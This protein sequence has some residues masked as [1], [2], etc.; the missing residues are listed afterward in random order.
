MLALITKFFIS[1]I[2]AYVGFCLVLFVIQRQMI[3]SPDKNFPMIEETGYAGF[4]R[5]STEDSLELIGW[6]SPP[7]IGKKTLVYF[8]GNAGHIGHRYPL[9]RSY[10]DQGYGV[11]LVEYRGYGG[12]PGSPSE[13]GFYRDARAYIEFLKARGIAESDLVLYGESIGSGVA[14]Q[15]A[16]EYPKAS[17]LLLVTPFSS[18]LAL[19]KKTFFFLPVDWLMWDKYDN[20]SKITTIKAPKF[21]FIAGQDEIVPAGSSGELFDKATAPK[22]RQDYPDKSHNSVFT[23]KLIADIQEVLNDLP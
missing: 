15:M 8:H 19:A 11:L 23:E 17:A 2:L 6:F 7:D 9:I 10:L 13:Q 4:I 5:V 12:N 14:V 22:A 3:Y 1:V 21:F 16:N 18:A 20:L